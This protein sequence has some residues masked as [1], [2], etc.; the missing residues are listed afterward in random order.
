MGERRGLRGRRSSGQARPVSI[1][2]ATVADLITSQDTMPTD[3][4]KS[5]TKKPAASK[6]KPETAKKVHKAGKPSNSFLVENPPPRMRG[7]RK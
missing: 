7:S 1:K 4:K 6:A 3:D 5:T 2:C